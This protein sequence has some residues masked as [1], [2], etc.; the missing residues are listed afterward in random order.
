MLIAAPVF[1]WHDPVHQMITA[2]A[3]R[4]LPA[5]MRAF[6]GWRRRPSR[7]RVLSLPGYVSRRDRSAAGGDAAVL[8]S[9]AGRKIHNVT[10]NRRQDE[11]S[12]E[13]LRGG[14]AAAVKRNDAQAAARFAGTL[15][16][17]IEDSTCPAH[18]LTPWYSPLELIRDL[19]APPADRRGVKLHTVME[20]SSPAVDLGSR[21]PRAMS[22][23]ALLDAI[24]AGVRDGRATVLEAAAARGLCEAMRRG[25][26]GRGG[27]G[28]MT[29]RRVAGGRDLLGPV[30]REVAG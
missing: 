16:H 9:C 23:A 21:T 7:G 12:L 10:W 17:M 26:T 4:S 19:L 24:Y 3:L 8:R 14:I 28:S 25:W 20:A 5:G 15:A 22:T 11:E 13:Y 29:G 1:A 27:A 2:A 30:G 6:L 18:A